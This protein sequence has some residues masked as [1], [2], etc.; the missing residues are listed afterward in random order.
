MQNITADCC[1]R[2]HWGPEEWGCV[3]GE[4]ARLQAQ[5]TSWTWRMECVEWWF[6]NTKT[7]HGLLGDHTCVCPR[8]RR[9]PWQ[10][11]RRLHC[12]SSV[13]GRW[14]QWGMMADRSKTDCGDG[15]TTLNILQT[16][17]LGTFKGWNVWY[18]NFISIKLLL[19]KL[20]GWGL[21]DWDAKGARSIPKGCLEATRHQPIWRWEEK[22]AFLDGEWT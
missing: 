9:L 10:E 11:P 15:C 4:K 3:G 14:G 12:Y 16:I 21:R 8:G 17:D 7:H 20:R 5:S 2:L 6:L 1:G 22:L 13:L 18:R 19:Q